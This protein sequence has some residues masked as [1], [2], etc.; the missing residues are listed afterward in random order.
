ML[1]IIK[2]IKMHNLFFL[3]YLFVLQTAIANNEAA[4]SSQVAPYKITNTP[5]IKLLKAI[6][7]VSEYTM[8][9]LD[10]FADEC[11]CIVINQAPFFSILIA[12]YFLASYLD[13]ENSEALLHSAFTLLSVS[14]FYSWCYTIMT[15]KELMRR[16]SILF[17]GFY[18][19]IFPIY[20]LAI[21]YDSY[22]T[23]L[24]T[25]GYIPTF[26]FS[27]ATLG[28]FIFSNDNDDPFTENIPSLVINNY[29]PVTPKMRIIKTTIIPPNTKNDIFVYT[30]PLKSHDKDNP[31]S[32]LYK[33]TALHTD[34]IS[35]ALLSSVVI[36][37]ALKIPEI[38][39]IYKIHET[40]INLANNKIKKEDITNNNVSIH[41][42]YN[43]PLFLEHCLQIN[44]LNE[45]CQS[46]KANIIANDKTLVLT[47]K[48][49]KLNFIKL[50]VV[51]IDSNA[52]INLLNLHKSIIVETNKLSYTACKT[53]TSNEY[54]YFSVLKNK[55]IYYFFF[56]LN[57]QNKNNFDLKT[58]SNLLK[59]SL[60]SLLSGVNC[61]KINNCL[62]IKTNDISSLKEI[63]INAI[64]AISYTT[65]VTHVYTILSEKNMKK[66]YSLIKK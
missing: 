54:R 65:C 28:A 43:N 61:F 47:H 44:S 62:I 2:L 38:D 7:N 60:W 18:K 4:I 11:R 14:L 24:G 9:H 15:P 26:L 32:L 22:T 50:K 16:T 27:L 12:N 40:T 56:S 58:V 49:L 5:I 30:G 36:N 1:L 64:K 21:I 39:E 51:N 46:Y 6:N 17:Y 23:K 59:L 8:F 48:D 35:L 31:M 57:A 45:K 13:V 10:Y 29:L 37:N 52:L 33:W 19:Y 63:L 3:L 25:N 42:F 66:K 53:I 41:P 34:D 20:S 55:D